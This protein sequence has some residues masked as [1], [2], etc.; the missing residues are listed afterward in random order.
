MHPRGKG[1]LLLRLHRSQGTQA[2]GLRQVLTLPLRLCT[3]KAMLGDMSRSSDSCS[4]SFFFSRS[5]ALLPL[6]ALCWERPH[7]H[8]LILGAQGY[9]LLPVS[10]PQL[11]EPSLACMVCSAEAS[12]CGR[13]RARPAKPISAGQP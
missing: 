7:G 6:F 12:R 4:D 8:V 13:G 11:P 5:M 2:A 9:P 10:S 3:L 1:L